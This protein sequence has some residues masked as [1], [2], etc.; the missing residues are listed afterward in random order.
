MRTEN[1]SRRTSLILALIVLVCVSLLL[2]GG[3]GMDGVGAGEKV[4]L[5]G[6]KLAKYGSPV[7]VM[8]QITQDG[9]AV[10]G[11]FFILFYDPLGST[12]PEQCG[13]R[14]EHY[15]PA[16]TQGNGAQISFIQ[17]PNGIVTFDIAPSQFKPGL[18]YELPFLPEDPPGAAALEFF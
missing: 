7:V 5:Q 9:E 1:R 11:S 10:P 17:Y 14:Q 15:F 12:G 4:D 3:E 16:G 13:L 6:I 2:G 8:G 18:A